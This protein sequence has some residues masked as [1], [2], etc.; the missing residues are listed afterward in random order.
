MDVQQSKQPVQFMGT[1]TI[2]ITE[3]TSLGTIMFTTTHPLPAIFTPPASCSSQWTYEDGSSSGISGGLLIQ[4]ANSIMSSCNSTCFSSGFSG[5]GKVWNSQVFSPGA[6]PHGY[7]IGLSMI[8]Q[9]TT[10]TTET[11]A[12]CCKESVRSSRS[13]IRLIRLTMK[14]RLRSLGLYTLTTSSGIEIVVIQQPVY[15]HLH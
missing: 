14:K 13:L 8:Q 3:L 9:T 7:T 10:D 12:V 6:C 5:Y 4:N 2:Q 15:P 11:V 1:S